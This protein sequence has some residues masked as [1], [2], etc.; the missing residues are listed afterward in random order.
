MPEPQQETEPGNRPAARLARPHLRVFALE[1][2]S[3]NELGLLHR[4][5]C[6]EMRYRLGG[7][8]PCQ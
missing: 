6:A 2:L 5:V 7:A 1:H 8:R 4:Q 3:D